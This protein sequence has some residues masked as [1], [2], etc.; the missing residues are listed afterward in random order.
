MGY[1]VKKYNKKGQSSEYKIVVTILKTLWWLVSAPFKFFFKKRNPGTRQSHENI[2][3]DRQFAVGKW[4]EIEQLVQLGSPSNYSRAILEADKLLD[5]LLKG[6]RAPGL[7]MGDRLKASEHRFSKDAYQA[8][9]QG[10]KVRNELVHNSQY[11]V[12]DFVT[13]GAIEN[14]RKA[15]QELI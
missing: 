15:I 13:R 1:R 2:S 7:T 4:Q 8:A 10:H 11:Q 6:H 5:H 3:L 14:F 12:T 9:W